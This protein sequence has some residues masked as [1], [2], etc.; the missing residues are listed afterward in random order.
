MKLVWLSD[1]HLVSDGT[2][3][4]GRDP[5]AN[6]QL[7]VE[8]IKQHHRD[9]AYCVLSGDLTENGMTEEY[10][11]LAELLR[12]LNLPLA[13]MVGNHDNR[14]NMLTALPIPAEPMNGFVQYKLIT[15]AGII[16]CL[17]TQIPG[18]EAGHLCAQRMT[19]I[20]EALTDSRDLPVF[21][22]MHHPPGPIDLP[23]QDADCLQNGE[24]LLS[25]LSGSP[26]VR[27]LFCGHVHRPVSGNFGTLPF[28]TTPAIVFQAPLPYPAWNWDVFEPT[29]EPPTM[30]LI[31]FNGSTT[32]VHFQ[33]LNTGS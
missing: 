19:W 31:F 29:N 14:E 33:P 11:L 32:T 22:F 8:E 6:L 18:Q 2:K 9:A 25:L 24:E 5:V 23:V 7:A 10:E 1:L 20:R 26:N 27:H 30:G 15:P 16:L 17:D 28:T 3:Q 12:P 21:V 4:M 13:P